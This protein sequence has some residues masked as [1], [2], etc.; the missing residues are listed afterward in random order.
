MWACVCI[1]Y[2]PLSLSWSK[3]K[4][5]LPINVAALYIRN[6]CFA[7]LWFKLTGFKMTD[8]ASWKGSVLI[9]KKAIDWTFQPQRACFFEASEDIISRFESQALHIKF[10][11]RIH[12]TKSWWE[13]HHLFI[14]PVLLNINVL[15]HINDTYSQVPIKRVGPNKQVGWIFHVNFLNK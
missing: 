4:L 10:M 5:D 2:F 9:H 11:Q 12:K 15:L 8:L 3:L 1:K 6:K 13:K 7:G 14:R